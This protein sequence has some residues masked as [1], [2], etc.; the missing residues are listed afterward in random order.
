[1]LG[2]RQLR[3]RTRTML[4]RRVLQVLNSRP[5]LSGL[6]SLSEPAIE[7]WAHRLNERRLKGNT[8]A[9][10]SLVHELS[11][12]CKSIADSS[13]EIFQP[14]VLPVRWVESTLA[15]LEDQCATIE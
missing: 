8:V 5:Q 15:T 7:A 13:S 9:I 11:A 6:A 4:E 12:H 10:V 14:R 2:S 1:M 3:Y